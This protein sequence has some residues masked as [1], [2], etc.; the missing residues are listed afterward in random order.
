MQMTQ[1]CE[2]HKMGRWYTYLSQSQVTL[3]LSLSSYL[4]D[5]VR[6]CLQELL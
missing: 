4:D 5:D 2:I 6:A 1:N 3:E